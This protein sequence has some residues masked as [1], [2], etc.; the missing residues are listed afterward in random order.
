MSRSV[1][2]LAAL[3]KDLEQVINS[4]SVDDFTGTPDFILAELLIQT[5]LSYRKARHDTDQW[6]GRPEWEPGQRL[7]KDN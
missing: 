1:T 2:D 5:I 6:K 3:R 7:V 4:N